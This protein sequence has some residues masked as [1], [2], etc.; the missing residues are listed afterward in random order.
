MM[1]FGWLL[2]LFPRAFRDQFAR[3]MRE[4]FSDQLCAAR[5]KPLA[6]AT[7]WLRTLSGMTMAAWRER[8]A[9]RPPSGGRLPIA[10]AF[11][12]DVRLACRM[13][14][15]APLFT[16][17]VVAALSLGIGA[18]T[19]IFSAL[20]ALVLRPLPA[21]TDG[22]RLVQI[23]RR[24]P[25][26]SE[27]VS[28]SYRWYAYV[29][30]H[31]RTLEDAA[32]WS[33][34]D[35][36]I[37]TG[38]EGVTA[39]GNIVSGNYFRVLGVRPAL[40]RFFLPDEDAAPLAH[41]VIVLSHAFWTTRLGGN[42]AAIGTT[43]RVNG[44]P[45]RIVGVAPEGFHGVFTPLECEA[46]VPMAVQPHVRPGRD[47][48]DANWL[49]MFARL[50]DGVAP[51]RARSDLSLLA[52][53]FV[54]ETG[55]W[56]Q[57]NAVR[58][59][60]LT[61]LPDDARKALLGFGAVLLGAAVLV[62]VIAAANVSS[63]L[64]A[65][66]IA[67]RREMGVRTAL[68]ASR[69]RLVRQLLTETLAL[70]LL[71][72]LGG[73][74]VAAA[75]TAALERLPLPS[76][77][78]LLLELSPDVRVL[79]FSLLVSLAAGVIFGIGPALGGA[80]RDPIALLRASSAGAGRRTFATSSLVVAQMAASLVLLAAAALFV[81]ALAAGASIDPGFDRSRV[82]VA[83]F[84][85]QAYGYDEGRGRAFF[86]SMRRRL[87]ATPGIE[88]VTYSNMVPLTMSDSGGTATVAGSGASGGEGRRMRVQ[89]SVV[90]T[91]YFETLRIPILAGRAFAATD[92][93]ESA[94]VAIVNETFAR[95]AWTDGEALGRTFEYGGQRVAIV[96]IA[97]DAR[98]AYVDEPPTPYVYRPVA[99]QWS[100]S[101]TLFVRAQ[102]DGVPLS[103][104][105]GAAVAG[106]DPQLPR[107]AVSTLAHETE[108]AVLP[109]RVAAMVTGVLGVAGLLLASLGLYGLIAYAV[110]L[111]SREIGVRM[112]LG[113]RGSDVVRLMLSGGFRLA[114][115]GVAVGLVGAALASRVIAAY[116]LNVSPFDPRAFAGA[117][118]LFLAVVLLASWLP[119][120]RAAST[121]PLVVLRSE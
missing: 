83:A 16:V 101:Q 36:T 9:S 32:V 60:P 33:R 12:A 65:R 42:P 64:A 1:V 62:L 70:F 89:A 57:Y 84:N 37:S 117:S 86:A 53:H 19:T 97:R 105:V 30:E 44:Q 103:A 72:A 7:L 118:A 58:L 22:T 63:L 51:E 68:G 112:A 14:A 24:N 48:T 90:D 92:T 6:F 66:A 27:G 54:A 102:G 23:D 78:A 41:R 67:R 21:T 28:A 74:A 26:F 49:W 11:V 50:R 110:H 15:R 43:I 39:S 119:A 71:G 35:L 59:T 82:V 85:T 88:S 98:Y 114:V 61:G 55:H 99:Q 120:R 87:E 104:A 4:V 69:W 116:L 111:R 76:D 5:G 31:A 18:V 121:D 107:P 96:G 17:V 94:R 113:A 47:L 80:G 10:Q 75:S 100:N 91:R 40:G 93:P 56:A 8:R 106:I 77:A 108:V 20:N 95:R 73:T 45:Y 81:R 34:A 25:D 3:D 79:V 2:R 29:R 115:A 52:A 46:W 109:Q 13:L 38:G